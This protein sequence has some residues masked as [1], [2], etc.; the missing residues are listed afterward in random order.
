MNAQRRIVI[1]TCRRWPGLSE[2]DALL[3]NELNE[4]GH[5]VVAQPWND[6]PVGTF[7]AADL[8]VLRSNWDFH[9]DL[10][11]FE[12]WLSTVDESDAVLHNSA[13]LVRNHNRKSYLHRLADL[14]LP[15]PATLSLDQFDVDV[16]RA[17][18]ADRGFEVVV[19]KP[20]WGASGHDVE[21]V[22][23]SGLD[24]ARADW[25]RRPDRR[26]LIVQ[27]FMPEIALG[28]FA[29]VFFANEFSHALHRQ[30]SASDFRVNSQYGGT[31]SLARQVDP[32]VVALASRVLATLATPPTYARIDVVGTGDAAKLMELE[33]NEPAL[34][35]HLAPG[36]ASRFAD[37]LLRL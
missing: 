32:A 26:G 1:A 36:S 4:R 23:S 12:D 37:A 19:L 15:T 20:A 5:D 14:G 30:P 24:D 33:V 17:W 9:H 29:L 8:I 34:G 28:E 18:M 10:A 31:M 21:R 2:S 13:D 27:E 16:I 25:E 35:L 7:T 6:G 3:A 11:A 22:S